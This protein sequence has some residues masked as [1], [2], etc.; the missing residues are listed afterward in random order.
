VTKLPDFADVRYG[1]FEQNLLDLWQADSDRPTPLFVYVHGGGWYSGEKEQVVTDREWL[2]LDLL[3]FMLAHGISVASID[4]RYTSVAP[5]PAPVHDA[6]RAIQ[7]L[8]SRAAEWNLDPKRVAAAGTSAGASTALWLNYHRDLAD[9][10]SGSPVDRESTRLCAAVGFWAQTSID[11]RVIGAWIGDQVLNHPVLPSCVGAR[12]RQEMESRY[13]EWEDLYR[14]FSP[15]NHVASGAGPVLLIHPRIDAVPAPDPDTA[16]HHS[17]FGVKL[18]EKADSVG[19]D[20][21][22]LITDAPESSTLGPCQFL[23]KHLASS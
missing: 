21:R 12:N 2:G 6:A 23:L 3:G 7:F 20:C 9:P 8:R 10:G 13:A 1:P 4:Y 15:I 19:A 17:M 16:I 14:E 18:K 22:L 5:L 11:P